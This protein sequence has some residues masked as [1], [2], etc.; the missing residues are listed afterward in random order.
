MFPVISEPRLQ[1]V[2][3]RERKSCHEA[4]RPPLELNFLPN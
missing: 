4:Q 2:E 3:K 1:N